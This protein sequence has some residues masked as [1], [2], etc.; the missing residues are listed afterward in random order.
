[1]KTILIILAVPF[2]ASCG[3]PLRVSLDY[4]DPDSGLNVGAGYSS[5]SGLEIEASK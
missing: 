5:K 4:T 2:F 1:M 3:L